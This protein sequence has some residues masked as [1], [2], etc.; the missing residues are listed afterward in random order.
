LIKGTPHGMEGI[1]TG[2][3]GIK[4]KKGGWTHM[5]IHTFTQADIDRMQAA[6]PRTA[7]RSSLKDIR[8]VKI[9]TGLPK[10]ERILDFISQIGNPY[11][12]RHGAYVVKISFADTDVTLE[13]RMLS[14]MRAK[15]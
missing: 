11:C 10:K 9:D 15:C 13:E 3:L 4:W 5:D 2:G 14:C 8:D 6:D 1:K 12:Y 7:E